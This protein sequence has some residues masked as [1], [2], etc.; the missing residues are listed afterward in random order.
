MMDYDTFCKL[1]KLHEQDKLKSSQIAKELCLDQRTVIQWIKEECYRPRKSTIGSSILDPFK[2]EINRMLE[3]HPYTATQVFQQL[4]ELHYEGSYNTVQRYVQKIRPRRSPAFLKLVFAPGECAQVDWGSFGSVNVGNTRRKLSFFAMV[5]CYS[6]LLYV[7]FTVSQTMEHWLSCHQHA[8]DFF[9][10]VP[11]RIMVDNLKSAVLKRTVGQSP[12]FNRKYLDFSNHYGFG[13]SACN[14]RKG[15]EKGIVESGVGYIKKNLLKGLDIKD[16]SHL[17]PACKIWLDT[18]ANVRT[19]GETRKSP[20]EL[21]QQERQSLQALPA[22][23]YDIATVSQVRAS[24]QFRVSLDSNRYSVPAEYA[25]SRLIMKTYPDRLCFYQE[26][27]LLARH[28]RCYDR[29]KDIENP[30]H[31]KPL[32]AKRRKAKTQL[33]YKRFLTLSPRAEEYYNALAAK[34]L[35]LA[36]HVRKI[37][38]LSEIYSPDAVERAMD[39][40]FQ[41][42][43]FSSEYI[44]NILE[45]RTR[46]VKEPG[47]LH[48]TRSQDLL[49]LDVESPDISIY[50]TQ[51]GPQ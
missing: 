23:P 40:A 9:G 19:H 42:Q 33:I 31:P 50:E 38:A 14:V 11:K 2:D 35:N 16:F 46:I 32:L 8:F 37:V 26:E 47:V 10:G 13:I 30:E 43:A 27:K 29:H 7:E 45:Q 36:E 51:G 22:Y 15:N 34:R 21:F 39:D 5:L 44:A 28:T 17:N 20:T 48:L 25:G 18:I 1:K 3:K 6:R 49:D 12:V 41:F 24:S 4:H